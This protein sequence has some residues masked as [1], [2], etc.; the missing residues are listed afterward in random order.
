MPPCLCSGGE[1]N[2]GFIHAKQALYKL[3]YHPSSEFAVLI[4]LHSPIP[5]G[6]SG[7]EPLD[8]KAGKQEELSKFS[9][10]LLKIVDVS[11]VLSLTGVG[12]SL[13]SSGSPSLSGLPGCPLAS[14]AL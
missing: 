4:G 5:L 7:A 6:F 1:S 2:P 12:F 9:E 14:T 8:F 13:P 3:S 10:I 11:F